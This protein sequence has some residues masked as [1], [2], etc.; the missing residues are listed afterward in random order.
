MTYVSTT[1]SFGFARTPL[2][3]AA[4]SSLFGG[5]GLRLLSTRIGMRIQSVSHGLL[6]S[7]IGTAR[8]AAL[9]VL[10]VTGFGG[11]AAIGGELHDAAKAGDITE[12]RR[13]IE[14]GAN[15]K[16]REDSFTPLHLAASGDVAQALIDAGANVNAKG[17]GGATPLHSAASGNVAQ[18]LIDNDA[19]VNAKDNE[20]YT[21]LDR[22][23]N[24]DVAWTLIDNGVDVNEIYDDGFTPLFRATKGDVVQALIDAGAD[25][26]VR[27]KSEE[28]EGY[29]PLHLA[30]NVEVAQVLID[31]G[32]DVNASSK[33]GVRASQDLKDT[34]KHFPD[35]AKV[36][37]AG[38]ESGYTPLFSAHNGDIV[39]LLIQAGADVNARNIYDQTPLHTVAFMGFASSAQALID[40]GADVNAEAHPGL[41]VNPLT[42]LIIAEKAIRMKELPDYGRFT[43]KRDKDS[44]DPWPAVRRDPEGTAQVLID[45]GA[46]VNSG[47]CGMFLSRLSFCQ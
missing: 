37:A 31:N 23:A 1:G 32:A 19:D 29:T 17:K 13:L 20:G 10:L 9:A 12:V 2:P 18:T 27:E 24:G 43:Y 30:T 4:G 34:L 3:L 41:N 44:W 38:S 46:N 5:L 40:H 26:N 16:V 15:V 7:T 14:A 35:F 25:V 11:G 28:N 42:M 33:L 21:P 45:A 39:R 22:A 47:W 36:S 6:R 8:T